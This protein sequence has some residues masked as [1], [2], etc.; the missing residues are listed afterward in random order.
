M[1]KIIAIANQKGGVGK[2]TTAVNLASALAM[3]GKKSLLIDFDPQSNASSHL[4]FYKGID[5]KDIY[6]ALSNKYKLSEI[7]QEHGDIKNL[8][9]AKSSRDL[10]ALEI[11]LVSQFSRESFLKKQLKELEVT[12][13]YILIDCPP[14]LGLLTINALTAAQ[15]VLIPVQCEYLA[16]EGLS[17]LLGTIKLVKSSL[18]TLLEIEGVVLTMFDKR[19]NLSR[20]VED[21][22]RHNLKE[23]V[24]K[25]VIPRNV[26]L[27][28]SSSHGL[29]VL[30]Y[31]MKSVGSINYLKLAKELVVKNKENRVRNDN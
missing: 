17:D 21:D 20:Q 9:L 1:A 6:N 13:D 11:E 22:I 3:A 31:D 29:P 5:K 4:G 30:L 28:E 16:M 26:R 10:S 12:F 27:S 8:F 15:S 18:N 14:S 23:I 7:I 2:T 19:N 25:T 24:F